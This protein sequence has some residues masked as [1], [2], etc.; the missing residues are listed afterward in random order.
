[1]QMYQ[2]RPFGVA[3]LLAGMDDEGPQL[4]VCVYL[5]SDQVRDA[6]VG[7]RVVDTTVVDIWGGILR[8]C[9]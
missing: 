2:S 5:A 1:M 6:W 8:G 3:L 7:E 4:Y 9:A